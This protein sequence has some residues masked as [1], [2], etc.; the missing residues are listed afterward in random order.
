MRGGRA[1][2]PVR[3]PE[4]LDPAPR[5]C[6]ER[7]PEIPAQDPVRVASGRTPAWRH[8]TLP[9]SLESPRPPRAPLPAPSQPPLLS[10]LTLALWRGE[11]LLAPLSS[12]PTPH[13]LLQAPSPPGS[14]PTLSSLPPGLGVPRVQ[15]TEPYSPAQTHLAAWQPDPEPLLR[16]EGWEYLHVGPGV[17]NCPGSPS[18]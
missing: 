12:A 18:V 11:A 7:G 5:G 16:R 14:T 4:I 13:P 8:P 1:R 6:P 17:V 15:A 10:S 2:P 9:P 3:G